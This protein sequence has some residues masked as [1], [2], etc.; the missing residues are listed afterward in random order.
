MVMSIMSQGMEWTLLHGV[1]CFTS[2]TMRDAKCGHQFGG[3]DVM[4]NLPER[5]GN[6]FFGV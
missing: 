3:S 6:V 1:I 5:H 4:V 2:K